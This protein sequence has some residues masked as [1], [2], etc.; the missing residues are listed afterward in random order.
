[1]RY[2]IIGWA[3]L[4]MIFTSFFL[5]QGQETT[6]L[7][8]TVVSDEVVNQTGNIPDDIWFAFSGDG[9]EGT[10][11]ALRSEPEETAPVREDIRSVKI[12]E[13]PST[14][15]YSLMLTFN[16]TGSRKWALMT[17]NHV[18]DRLAIV[19][20]SRVVSAPKVM[21]AIEGGKCQISGNFTY[22][23]ASALKSFLGF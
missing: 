8:A 2:S 11:F 23:E 18:G 9:E 12:K 14:G 10:L 4:S 5:L 3:I 7:F 15:S 6:P 16:E 22:D 1:M 20:D 13:D 21:A 17:G 19:I